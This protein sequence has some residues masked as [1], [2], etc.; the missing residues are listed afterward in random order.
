MK[1][2][3]KPLPTLPPLTLPPLLLILLARCLSHSPLPILYD[4][5]HRFIVCSPTPRPALTALPFNRLVLH[6]SYQSSRLASL[7]SPRHSVN[8]IS[9]SRRK[10]QCS[11]LCGSAKPQ[12]NLRP[13]ISGSY[14]SGEMMESG[15]YGVSVGSGPGDGGVRERVSTGLVGLARSKSA[16]ENWLVL[17]DEAESRWEVTE[18][19]ASENLRSLR[20]R[21]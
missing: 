5:L 13:T 11:A 18:R 1:R 20:G 8:T 4:P 9:L 10:S 19:S 7:S 16:A 2:K 15:R 12:G 21:S 17:M 6:P 14:R 3:I